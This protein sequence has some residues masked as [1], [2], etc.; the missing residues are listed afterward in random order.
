MNLNYQPGLGYS[1]A[2]A[3]PYGG[4]GMVTGPG[5]FGQQPISTLLPANVAPG[6]FIRFGFGRDKSGRKSGRK[7]GRK[8]GK[9]S[10]KKSG[11]KVGK[12]SGRKAS[13]KKVGSIKR[14]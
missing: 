5:F 7:V 1:P 11:R 12:K 3:G 2:A 6:Q 10:G 13:K 9:K 14:K 4:F 8:L